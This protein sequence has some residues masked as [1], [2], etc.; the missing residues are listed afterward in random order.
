MFRKGLL[1][2]IVAAVIAA[3]CGGSPSTPTPVPPPPDPQPQPQPQ[4]LPPPPQLSITR[5]LAF[6]DSMTEGTVSPSLSIFTLDAGRPESYP[7]KL[8]ALLNARYTAQTISVFNA[9]NAGRHTWEDR[10]RLASSINASSPQLVLLIEGA[11]DLNDVAGSTTG[12][13]AGVDA[14]VGNM[15]DMV[16]DT[17]ARGIPIYIGTLPPQ[18]LP[19][20]H[21]S[22]LLPRYNGGLKTMAAKKGAM[23][24]DLNA[25]IPASMIGSDGLHPT[26]QGYQAFAQ[27]FMDAIKQQYEVA[28]S[29]APR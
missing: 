5:I 14:T 7:Y 3:G 12:T 28:S 2:G 20:G 8:Q 15:E 19:K 1:I 9:G 26:E 6:G 13:N 16:R 10:S 24:V 25:L 29:I 17:V 27:A 18:Q 21:A 23:I 22:A 11:N 4:P